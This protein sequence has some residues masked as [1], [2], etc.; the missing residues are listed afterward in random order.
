MRWDDLSSLVGDQAPDLELLSEQGEPVR[1]R[2]FCQ[3]KPALVS[4]WRHFGC[5]CGGERANRFV[6]EYD[7]Y[8]DAGA[9]VVTV[10]QGEPVRERPTPMNTASN[11]RCSATPTVKLPPP[12]GFWRSSRSRSS[13]A[14]HSPSSCWIGEAIE[15]LTAARRD[16]E[17][18][19]VDSLCLSQE[20]SSSTGQGS[21]VSRI[22]AG[23]VR[24]IP[25][26]VPSNRHQ[27]GELSRPR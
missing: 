21:C 18:P 15:K 2:E 1:L 19:F 8:V 10:G 3:D 27:R 22:G 5:G 4:F 17:R 7:G 23:T 20:S 25:I 24:V 16:S 13:K 11:A 14:R 12:T 6:D 9:N 26:S